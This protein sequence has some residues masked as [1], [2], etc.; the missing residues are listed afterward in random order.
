[1]CNVSLIAFYD[2]VKKKKPFFEKEKMYAYVALVDRRA[3][4][5]PARVI[6]HLL[7]GV[8]PATDV[9]VLTPPKLRIH[10]PQAI[11]RNVPLASYKGTGGYLNTFMK[12][13][14]ATLTEYDKVMFLDL[15]V[16]PWRSPQ[17]LF[18][19]TSKIV[20]A[21]AAYWLRQPFLSSGGPVVFRPAALLPRVR[22]VL[23]GPRQQRYPSEMDWFN[24]AFRSDAETL[25]GFYTLLNGEFV[26]HDRI[27]GYWGRQ[28]NKSASRVLDEATFVHCIAGWKP[29]L[30]RT[31]L[32]PSA[33]MRRIYDKWN[34]AQMRVC[35]GSFAPRAYFKPVIDGELM[36]KRRSG[37]RTPM[38]AAE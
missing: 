30:S 19:H 13:R 8:D 3:L 2:Y 25:D 37:W 27:F 4:E 5:C 15:D 33:E 34:D 1:M 22:H 17:H 26:A 10:V 28:K 29:W 18:V 31:R 23:D 21:P 38:S 6:T 35:N 20:A 32:R 9:V 11:V 36:R 16:I 7:K 14:A 24:D 12:F